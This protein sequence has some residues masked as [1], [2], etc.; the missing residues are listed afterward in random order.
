MNV[1]DQIITPDYAIY[2]GDCV[3]V[4]SSLADNSSI[5]RC[6]P[7]LFC[8]PLQLQLRPSGHVQLRDAGAVPRAQYEYSWSRSPVSP[9]PG[10][11]TAVHCTDVFRQRLP[12]WDFPHEIIRIHEKH[13]FQY[14][15]RGHDLEGAAE[16]PHANDGQ[17]P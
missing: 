5:C 3:D 13:G 9:K 6:T 4:V 12:L 11:I 16:G 10:R 15:N 7:R 2:N 8:G 14:R 1:K 17:K